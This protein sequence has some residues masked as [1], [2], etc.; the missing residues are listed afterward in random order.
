M[1]TS[2]RLTK[3]PC[4]HR[5]VPG[6]DVDLRWKGC[7]HGQDQ[8]LSGTPGPGGKKSS[9]PSWHS[10][11][12]AFRRITSISSRSK[13]T[14]KTRNS[15]CT[16]R[17]AAFVSI[18]SFDAAA[19]SFRN[20][21]VPPSATT[22]EDGIAAGTVVQARWWVYLRTNT[23]NTTENSNPVLGLLAENACAK[24]IQSTSGVR[25][26]TWALVEPVACSQQ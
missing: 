6:H 20:F 11:S 2:L 24:V 26:Q 16:G 12:L 21:K 5:S 8:G 9:W 14:C 17:S 7:I 22:P 23:S 19:K 25:G 3:L 10:C 15:A 18:G 4:R 13:S 1:A